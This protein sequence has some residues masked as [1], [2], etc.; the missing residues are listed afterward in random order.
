MK[1]LRLYA[2]LARSSRASA[3]DPGERRRADVTMTDDN[4]L[5]PTACGLGEQRSVVPVRSARALGPCARPVRR[6]PS[7]MQSAAPSTRARASGASSSATDRRVRA[8][9][10]SALDD[11]AEPSAALSSIGEGGSSR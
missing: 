6:T 1:V 2:R 7:A 9:S 4:A 10:T 5:S 3:P 8:L 11:V